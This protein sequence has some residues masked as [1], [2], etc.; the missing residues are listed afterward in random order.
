MYKL[1]CGETPCKD[2]KLTDENGVE[3]KCCKC[4]VEILPDSIPTIS[5]DLFGS[6]IEIDGVCK[7]FVRSIDKNQG[8]KAIKKI[9]FEDGDERIF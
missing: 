6:Y 1:K 3:I 2:F 8:M 5:V 9:I 7:F 4:S